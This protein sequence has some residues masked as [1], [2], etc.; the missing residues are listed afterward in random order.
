MREYRLLIKQDRR[1]KFWRWSVLLVGPYQYRQY[2]RRFNT[3]E[4]ATAFAH[5]FVAAVTP[6]WPIA[7]PATPLRTFWIVR[8][9][10]E[11]ED[12]PA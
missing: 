9:K 1:R 2:L 10:L 11:H 3:R 8:R 12:G 7:D 6:V 5:R 4:E